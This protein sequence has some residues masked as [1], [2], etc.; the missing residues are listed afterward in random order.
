MGGLDGR[1]DRRP[2]RAEDAAFRFALFCE[3]HGAIFAG[4][5]EPLRGTLLRQQLSAQDVGYHQ[6]YPAGRFDIV[7]L[8]GTPVGR[9]V[10]AT[11]AKALVLVDLAIASAFQRR[12]LARRLLTDMLADARCVRLH[13]A[14]GN[15]GARRLYD[16]LGFVVVSSNDIETTMEANVAGA[17]SG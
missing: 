10:T 8:D 11:E 16:R 12:G 1:L 17:D 14:L 13:V 9:I 3:T 2:E 6:A 7:I 15:V 4:L 5:K